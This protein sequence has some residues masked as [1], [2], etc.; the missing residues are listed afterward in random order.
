M[1]TTLTKSQTLLKGRRRLEGGRFNHEISSFGI[2]RSTDASLAIHITSSGVRLRRV[3]SKR[4]KFIIITNR[5]RKK[6]M[7][8]RAQNNTHNEYFTQMG[9]T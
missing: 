6:Y 7:Y 9:L 8:I 2:G 5:H 4:K 1:H 3:T